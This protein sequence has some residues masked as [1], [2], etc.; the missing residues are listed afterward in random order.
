M[1]IFAS[2]ILILGALL[3]GAIS[4]GPSFVL[5]ARIAM[6]KSRADGIAAALGMGVGGSIFSIL[7]LLG[8]QAVLTN[9]PV[10]YFL[11][12]VFGGLY[13][14]WLALRIWNSSAPIPTIS[15]QSKGEQ[16]KYRKS[17]LLALITQMSNPKAAVIYGSI[18]AALLPAEIP[19]IMFFLLP[20]LVFMVETGWYLVV[21]FVL[22]SE[23]PRAIYLKSQRFYDRV[24]ATVLAGIGFRLVLS[25]EAK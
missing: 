15:S 12:K 23:S 11:L 17:F 9:V 25:A 5:V 10:L 16:S 3:A 1:E 22:T 24:T 14:I 20:P 7:A 4:P 18:F 2:I 8:L 21:T 19:P 13:L 6:A